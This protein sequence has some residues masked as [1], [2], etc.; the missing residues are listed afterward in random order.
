MFLV[1]FSLFFVKRLFFFCKKCFRGEVVG[2]GTDAGR[3]TG[4]GGS[5]GV[6]HRVRGMVEVCIKGSISGTKNPHRPT[7]KPQPQPKKN[8]TASHRPLDK[9]SELH[10]STR[11]FNLERC[12]RRRR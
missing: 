3:E 8:L 11:F 6:L 1:V 10:S 7:L 9:L 4:V 12:G 2:G 5:E